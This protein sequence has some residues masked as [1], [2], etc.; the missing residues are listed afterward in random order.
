M[1]NCYQ[2][3]RFTDNRDPE[4]ASQW[5]WI[6]QQVSGRVQ[7]E[8]QGPGGLL[9][10]LPEV[11]FPLQGTSR[12]VMPS[13]TLED[14]GLYTFRKDSNL[15]NTLLCARNSYCPNLF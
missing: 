3:P 2:S 7:R 10:P 9:G 14:L 6:T 15:L 13:L 12:A 4:R 8:L 5:P 1:E 11:L